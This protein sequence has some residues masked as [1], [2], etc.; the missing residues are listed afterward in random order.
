MGKVSMVLLSGGIG[1]RM[2]MSIPKQ[3][4]L[5]GGKPM[6]VHVLEKVEAISEIEEIIIPSPQEYIDKTEDIIRNHQFSKRTKVI[7]GGATRQES[8]YKALKHVQSESVIIHEAVR[9]FVLREEY[10]MLIHNEEKN[11]TY[12]LDIPF[13]VLEGGEYIEKNLDRNRLINI[14]LPQKFDTQKLLSAHE[15][16]IADKKTFTEDVSLYFYYNNQKIKVL[17][18]TEYNIKVTKPIDQKIGEIIYRDYI[19]GEE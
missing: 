2:K 12:G 9:P 15:Q 14:Q 8:T 1:T 19:L 6:I 18:G 7:V 4:L 10:E 16:A 11:A 13:T 5:I 3:F 17:E